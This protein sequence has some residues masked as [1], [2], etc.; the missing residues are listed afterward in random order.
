M[1]DTDIRD[2]LA[3][4]TRH[5]TAPPGLLDRVRAGGRRRVVRRRTLVAAGLATAAAGAGA[6]V[7][8]GPGGGDDVAP[9][10]SDRLDRPT[11]G[12]LAGDTGYLAAVRNEWR[13]YVGSGMPTRGEPHVVWAG[14]TPAGPVALVAQRT[15]PVVVPG[16]GQIEYG[17]TGWAT[18]G[19][20]GAPRVE[21]MESML[22][23]ARNAAG[24][25]AGG[26]LLVVLD[27]AG[28]V[29]FSPDLEYRADGA[30]RR[31]FRPV[32]FDAD[33]AAV[34]RGP[35][36]ALRAAGGA[37]VDLARITALA[38][39]ERSEPFVRMLERTLP[40]GAAVWPAAGGVPDGWDL[41]GVPGYE[42]DFGYHL[43]HA[44]DVTWLLR[45]ATADGRRFVVQTL[46]VGDRRDRLFLLLGVPEP[47]YLGTVDPSAPLPV[48]VRL[49][50]GRGVVVAA[51]SAALRYRAGR[52][53]WLPV[54]GDA[55]LLPAA[56]TEAEV[57]R[58]G[59]PPQRVP[60]GS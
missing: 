24:V 28:P 8:W 10:A 35:E 57:T 50:D 38:A 36:P 5:I 2:A 23:G 40:G 47:A 7:W 48:R 4:A 20:D 41:R 17:L 14:R 22:T 27:E 37:R 13:R 51:E 43:F 18:P 59:R 60:L 15:R 42:D 45:G 49:P 56:A 31:T 16:A 39:G 1:T 26:G 54:R 9:P 44:G 55:A 29:G 58:P 6:G 46:T 21:S 33:G 3:A 19:G 11:R 34:L 12:D 52:G 25:L 53:P 30:I 32:A